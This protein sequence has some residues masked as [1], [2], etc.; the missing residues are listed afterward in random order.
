MK[1]E[2][3]IVRRVHEEFINH[4]SRHK[5]I[6]TGA[7]YRIIYEVAREFK[8]FDGHIAKD[9]T[10]MAYRNIAMKDL[11]RLSKIGYEGVVLLDMADET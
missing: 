9:E 6:A 7:G 11:Q 8:F 3:A 5:Y 1:V 4:I 2:N 10:L